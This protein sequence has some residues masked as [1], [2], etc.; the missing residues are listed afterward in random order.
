MNPKINHENISPIINYIQCPPVSLPSPTEDSAVSSSSSA[1]V[2]D[3]G[4]KKKEKP[5]SQRFGNSRF[6]AP[7][8]Y[9]KEALPIVP[10][11]TIEEAELLTSNLNLASSKLFSTK[12]ERVILD[13][14]H[15]IK[16]RTTQ[17]C[18]VGSEVGI[19]ECRKNTAGISWEFHTKCMYF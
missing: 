3:G 10:E 11:S 2:A 17:T 4:G 12:W 18:Q 14:A 13:E 7:P 19:E 16:S 1:A 9:T 8:D 6:G 15:R 5:Q